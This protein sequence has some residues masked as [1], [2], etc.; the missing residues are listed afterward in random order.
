M[1]F[2]VRSHDDRLRPEIGDDIAMWLV[3]NFA[4]G[5]P[6]KPIPAINEVV[7]A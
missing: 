4:G 7:P 6:A 2:R 5:E 3:I 1:G